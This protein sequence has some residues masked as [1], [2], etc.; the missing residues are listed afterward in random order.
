MDKTIKIILIVVLLSSATLAFQNTEFVYNACTGC[1]DE[2]NSLNQTGNNLTAD[3]WF[4]NLNASY[5]QNEEW[6]NES[7]DTMTGNLNMGNNDITNI[8][9]LTVNERIFLTDTNHWLT[10]NASETFTGIAEHTFWFHHNTEHPEGNIAYLFTG[11]A[12]GQNRTM[13]AVQLGRNNSAGVLGNSWQVMPNNLTDNLTILSDCLL[14]ANLLDKT[15]RVACDTDESGS[16]FIVHDDVQA[17]GHGFFDDGLRVG[18]EVDFI[19]DGQNANFFNGSLHVFTPVTF[20]RGVVE[21][22]TI[23]ALFVNFQGS[24]SPFVNLQSDIGD[25][26]DV[27]DIL[28]SNDECANAQGFSGDGN[29]IMQTNF[30]TTNV[31]NTEIHFVYSLKNMLGLNSFTVEMDNGSGFETIFTDST[32]DVTLSSQTFDL[33]PNYDNLADVSLRFT[34]DVTKSDR[35]CFV[36]TVKVNGTEMITTIVNVSDFDTTILGGD[37]S[38]SLVFNSSTQTWVFTPGNV[39][40]T[41]VVETSLNVTVDITLNDITISDWGDI[42]HGDLTGLTDDDHIQYLLAD[43]TRELSADWNA[44]DFNIT[45]IFTALVNNSYF[46]WNGTY[47]EWTFGDI[48]LQSEIEDMNTTLT[49]EDILLNARATDLNSTKLEN[50]SN[51]NFNIL[52]QGNS[53]VL[54]RTGFDW[55]NNSNY[56]AA[57]PT[58]SYVTQIGDSITCTTLINTDTNLT[59]TD[60]MTFVNGSYEG[61]INNS[62]A[63]SLHRHS[64]LSASDG[65]PDKIVYTDSDGILYA[66]ASPLGIDILYGA[67]V[68]TH[69]TV[70]NNI[71][72]GGT[73]DGVD[74]AARDHAQSHAITSSSDHTAGNNVI[75]STTDGG[76][77]EEIAHGVAG[78]YLRSSAVDGS[79]AFAFVNHSELSGVTSDQHHNQSTLVASD[80]SLTPVKI[81]S[82]GDIEVGVSTVRNAN[83]Y[84]DDGVY[85]NIDADDNTGGQA[86]AIGRHRTGSAG[87]VDL[88]KIFENGIATLSGWLTIKS[89]T[90]GLA[91]HANADEL[92]IE[93]SSTQLGM[94]MSSPS[95]G[96]G[97]I[98]FGDDVS[99]FSGQIT[100]NHVTNSFQFTTNNVNDVV[101]IESDG[102]VSMKSLV[103]SYSGGKAYVCV[104]DN[105]TMF[106]TES[107][108]G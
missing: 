36:D 24:I 47:L 26:L 58:D 82:N 93:S 18:K 59:K 41:N 13:I 44:G 17:Y 7:G 49:N 79:P 2:I 10:R 21:G 88:L 83:I 86:F 64:E 52:M 42:E 103:G 40:F 70:G 98:F 105:G 51:A 101:V 72:V 95:G 80:G 75:F 92:M 108:C 15:I 23:N 94:T 16:D 63:D 97:N 33:S 34:C 76:D 19:L 11:Q 104:Y 22:D 65:S 106:A 107:L 28:C 32:T 54:D 61:V 68:G 37:G 89:G 20:E 6:V 29:I 35:E 84:S 99:A 69:L 30:S 62:M 66:D 71:I 46:N 8:F 81:D 87:G 39:S 91:A 96:T 12:K 50:G 4:G 57:C 43:G 67:E 77:I 85:I 74:I 1:D 3:N 38:A 48:Y 56:P 27:A 53:I 5:I 102:D 78:T 73:V 90:G 100:Y 9:N 60:V 14:V 25:W 45:A 31:N 55:T